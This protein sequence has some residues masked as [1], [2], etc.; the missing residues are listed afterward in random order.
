M[1][2]FSDSDWGTCK[3]TRR[4]QTGHCIYVFGNLVAWVSTRQPIVTLSS[5]EAEYVALT[6]AVK[7]GLY[8]RSL[9]SEIVGHKNVGVNLKGD[10]QGSLFI[11]LN[12]VNNSRTKHIDIRHHF[13]RNQLTTDYYFL[14]K[15]HT[16]D[17]IADFFT[18]PLALP[19][20]SGFMKY[21][22]K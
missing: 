18:K 2:Q 3:Q 9:I 8:F 4:S 6:S 12:S 7:D 14:T 15:V 5:T 1:D 20:F 16:K 19:A 17:N 13:I 22:M 11:A 21:I 10:N